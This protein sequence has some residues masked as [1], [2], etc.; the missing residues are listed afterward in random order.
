MGIAYGNHKAKLA[1]V[2]PKLVH[3]FVHAPT[4]TYIKIYFD[5]NILNNHSY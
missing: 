1:Y 3:P 5:L 2:T 4:H